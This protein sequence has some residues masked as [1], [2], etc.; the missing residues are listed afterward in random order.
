MIEFTLVSRN[1]G[2]NAFMFD[3]WQNSLMKAVH[4]MY[5]TLFNVKII[6]ETNSTITIAFCTNASLWHVLRFL[7]AC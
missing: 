1:M 4:H 5:A 7:V 6:S 2:E 3:V